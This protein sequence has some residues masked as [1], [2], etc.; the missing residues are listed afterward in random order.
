[1]KI[2]ARRKSMAAKIMK[3]G[4]MAARIISASGE[5]QQRKLISLKTAEMAL[6]NS[7]KLAASQSES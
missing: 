5:S 3:N 1:M 6:A 7:R 2:E 4:V